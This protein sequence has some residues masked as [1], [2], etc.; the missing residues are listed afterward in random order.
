MLLFFRLA[1][2]TSTS[3]CLPNFL[4][5][6]RWMATTGWTDGAGAE[7]RA[8]KICGDPEPKYEE[9]LPTFFP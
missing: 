1:A 6:R 5:Q 7:S 4:K 8:K 3:S 2:N 9:M